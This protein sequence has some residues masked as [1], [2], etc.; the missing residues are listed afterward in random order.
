MFYATL[1]DAKGRKP[2]F[3]TALIIYNTANIALATA[4]A[5]FA[6]FIV[7]RVVQGLGA[8]AFYSVGAGCI[9]DVFEPRQRAR[10]IAVFSMGP[11]LGP[12]LGPSI[13]GAIAQREGW[14][15]TFGFLGTPSSIP[16]VGVET[17]MGICS[18]IWRVYSS[19]HP[20]AT[21]G[22]APLEGRLQQT[23]AMDLM[24]AFQTTSQVEP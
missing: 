18:N 11:Q 15:W 1:A 7:L 2:V 14:R 13:G 20:F 6:S 23:T 16:C 24:A 17:N 21:A 3:V 5:H 10:A 4:P 19:R 9:A 22:D 12:I 8:S